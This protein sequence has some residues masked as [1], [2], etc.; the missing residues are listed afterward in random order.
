[1]A[2]P[3]H[4]I[5]R[6]STLPASAEEAFA[7]HE[8]PGAFERLVPPW[9][10][11][12]VLERTGGIRDGA[13]TVVRVRAGPVSLRWVAQHREYVPGRRFVDEQVEGPFSHW[14]HQ[15]LFEP[16]GP[17]ASRYTDRIEFAPP[18]GTLG[19]AAGMW[20]A[21]PRTERMVA[22]RH[23]IL[24]DDLAAHARFR[25]Q[26]P[27]HIAVTGA[28]GLLGSA[29]LPFL[30][31]GGHRV[32]PVTRGSRPPDAIRWDPASGAID[33]S[34]FEGLDAVV[35]LAGENVGLRWSEERKRRIRDSRI[36]GTRLLAETLAG[37]ERRPR[38]L[39]S[40]SAIGV[41]G[42]RGDEVLGEDAT[43]A[44]PP[45]D[46]FVELG[47]E[48]EAATEP[49]RAAGIRVVILRFGIVLTPAGGALGRML[50]PFRLGVGG[51][52]GSGTQWVSWISVDDA[53][54][55]V[56]HALLNDGLSGAVNAVAP[57]PATGRTFA[58]T[59]GRVLRRPALIPAPAPA[60]KLLFGEMADTAL[61]GSQRV[62]ASRLLA[63]GYSF[64]HPRLE[65]ALRHLL[66]R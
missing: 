51:P 54:G 14:N 3:Y 26:S 44:G 56:H 9:E 57:E 2:S 40:A 5:E 27:M 34:A 42:D 6:T 25:A 52:L 58:A 15:H 32:T 8:R 45:S 55:V 31:T 39:V 30:T 46:F 23:S 20:L 65:T 22:Y 33:A 1:M 17:S 4:L 13:R 47:H 10:R 38:V 12:E 41:Y 43:P 7:W 49:A 63:S 48:W 66:G 19:T 16:L 37:L 61:L 53:I 59:L 64:R 29:L 62:S 36:G 24:R 35:H 18:F 11:V 21:K 60:L 50:L 28:G